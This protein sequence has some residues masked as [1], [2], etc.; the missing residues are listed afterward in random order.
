MALDST[1]KLAVIRDYKRSD[2]DTGSADVQVALLTTRINGLSDHFKQH[3]HDFHS[4]EG[5]LRMIHRRRRLLDYIRKHDV[6]RYR[7][8]IGRLGLRR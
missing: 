5:L 1:S 8:L 6:A 4:R 2:A 7:E 3:A